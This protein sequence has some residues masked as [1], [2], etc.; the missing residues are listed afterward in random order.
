[1]ASY[2]DNLNDTITLTDSIVDLNDFLSDTITM[3]D[4]IT[5]EYGHSLS[6]ILTLQETVEV[7]IKRLVS[8]LEDYIYTTDAI[9]SEWTHI[10]GFT[11]DSQT[12]HTWTEI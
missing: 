10:G 9:E 5:V 6:D 8:Y 11:E 12:D 4:G 1:M 2:S 7:D 3:S